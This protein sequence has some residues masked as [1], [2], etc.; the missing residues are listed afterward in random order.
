MPDLNLQDDEGTLENPEGTGESIDDLTETSVSEEGEVGESRGGLMK[1]L[2]IV[3]GVLILGGGTVFLLNS[4][5]IIKLWGGAPQTTAMQYEEPAASEATEGG[6]PTAETTPETRMVETPALEEKKPARPA[7]VQ[8]PSSTAAKP[9][10]PAQSAS[11][12]AGSGK[13][14]QMQGEYTVQVSA[15]REEGTAK[16]IVQRLEEAGYPAFVES[17]PYTD[18]SWFTVR[19]G[20]YPS[21]K[22]AQLAVANFAEELQANHWIDKVRSR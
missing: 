21:R 11:P 13:L 4:L 6:Q 9:Q 3:A 19:I 12:S 20:R 15:W 22:D 7:G 10:T 1:I 14:E 18:G 17:R 5:G 2:I 16:E 8:A